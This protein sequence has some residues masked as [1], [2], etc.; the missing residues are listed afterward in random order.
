MAEL[1]DSYASDFAQLRTSIAGKLENAGT[2]EARKAALRR[3]EMEAEEADE[4]LS[5][6]DIECQGFPQSVRSRYA[7]RLR[8]HR[9]ELDKL[10]K[11]IVS[12]LSSLLAI[13]LSTLRSR[14]S[15]SW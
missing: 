12:V 6:M 14:E 13:L 4:I 9:A 1:F 10:R 8:G 2:G 7:V 5:Q 15:E 11:D 3:A